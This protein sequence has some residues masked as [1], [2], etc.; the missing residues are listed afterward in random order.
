VKHN[1]R[2]SLAVVLLALMDFKCEAVV[3]G[4]MVEKIS[5]RD[6]DDKRI[7]HYLWMRR[8]REMRERGEFVAEGLKV[9]ERLLAAG[10]GVES[11]LVPKDREMEVEALLRRYGYSGVKLY[12]APK[13]LLEE[14]VGFHLYQGVMALGRV[15]KSLSLEE[16][17]SETSEPRLWIGLDGLVNAE[18]VGVILRNAAALGVGGVLVGRR[19]SSA[20]LRRTVRCS[21]GGVFA[22]KI[23]EGVDLLDAVGWMRKRGMVSV[24]IELTEGAEELWNLRGCENVCLFFGEE[25]GG[26]SEGIIRAVEQRLFIPMGGNMTSLNVANAVGITLYE[27]M[28]Q[29]VGGYAARGRG[30]RLQGSILDFPVKGFGHYATGS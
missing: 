18:N 6:L 19:C 30:R 28:R 13:R 22:L 9:V 5:I 2:F 17:W 14:M 11:V 24:A 1:E 3:Q 20:W 15:P 29:R 12:V 10:L 7:E 25:V 23:V 21:M 8:P 27:V 16:L 4:C 26:V